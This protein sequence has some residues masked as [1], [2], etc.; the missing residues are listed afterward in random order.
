MPADAEGVGPA[1]WEDCKLRFAEEI[2]LLILDDEKGDVASSLPA[3]SLSV[4][5]AGAVLMDLALEN[6]IDTDLRNLMLVDPAPVGDDLLDPVLAA[7]AKDP[8]DRP[9]S[10]WV[11]RAAR[12]GDE[13]RRKALAGLERRGI[14]D[15][16]DS[17]QFFRSRSVSRSRR[18]PSIDGKATEDVQLRIMR[19]LF[20][21][22]IPDP[23]D[24]VIVSLAASCG[25]FECLL[26]RDELAQVRKRIDVIGKMDRIGQ[27]VAHAL[28]RGVPPPPPPPAARPA[29]EIPQA[30]GW[31]VAGNAFAV[32]GD[33]PSFLVRQYRKS[34][35]VF[36]IRAFNRRFIAL[37]GPEANR[38]VQ[39][40]GRIH[41]RS[42]ETWQRF[43]EAWGAKD[44]L[45]GLDGPGH[46]RMRKAQ[47]R[48]FSQ[49]F[50]EDRLDEVVEI[51]RR[52]IA[53]WPR[54]RPIAGQRA[55]Q[56][57]I[58]EQLA[59]LT[60]GVSARDHVD[61]LI[62]TLDGLLEV[63]VMQR[64]P[65]WFLRLPRQ[66]RARRRLDALIANVLAFHRETSRVDH[67][68]I[69]DLLE[70]HQRDPQFFPETDLQIAVLGPFFAGIDTAA[71]TSAFA[72]YALLKHP[73]LLARMTAEADDFFGRGSLTA[74]G[75]RGLDV[76]R[77]IVL[78]TLRLYPAAPVL[79][80]TVANAFEFAGY[81]VPA[82]ARVIVGHTVAH[83]LPELYPDPERFDIER[84]M[85]ERA[86]HEQPGAFAPFG[87]GTHRCLG[88][89]FAET[90]IALT[91]LTI[92]R[93][94]ELAPVP[95]GYELKV[96]RIPTPHPSPSFRF[97]ILN[98]RASRRRRSGQVR[99]NRQTA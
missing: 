75:L 65:S 37:A 60:T 95:P 86:E 91:L 11:E 96:D 72:L 5:L 77:R 68:L 79:S 20:S 7:I 44:G 30:A 88:S 33:L 27:S 39:R 2:L 23:R 47:T 80:R 12:Q 63:H 3:H 34:G 4:V 25:L 59:L 36:R 45:I 42:H 31:P 46:V 62:D 56:Y 29:E 90:Q 58:T 9:I 32:I 26:S 14:L 85:P 21:D 70:L 18:Y 35:P 97:R 87:L 67:D 83:H 53:E 66:R 81:T 74:E 54:Q 50:I 55:M 57:V 48:G 71:S 84:F 76:T 8:R 10:C 28:T 41:L 94:V 89:R 16:E 78:E 64:R 98:E 82:G 17:E 49:R 15:S 93:E 6:R 40:R 1:R 51:T 13:I 19:L 38:F 24:I 69:D 43:W 22:D 92:I 73:E 52:M 99:R 61:E